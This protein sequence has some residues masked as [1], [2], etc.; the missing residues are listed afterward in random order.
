MNTWQDT[1]GG[2][3]NFGLLLDY[4]TASYIKEFGSKNNTAEVPVPRLVAVYYNEA[5][6]STIHD[7][8][9]AD[10]DASL[11][12]FT[13]TFDPDV[14]QMVSGY[15]VKSFL[16]FDLSSIPPNAAMATMRFIL[17]R[18]IEN[19]VVNNNLTEQMFVRVATS[20]YDVLPEYQI[21]STFAFNLFF[22]VVLTEISSNLL[23]ITPGDRGFSSQNF[24]Q[25]IINDDVPLGSFMVQY[26]NE[27]DGIS[28]Y[29]VRDSEYDEISRRP[30]IVVEY[31][32]VP[33]PR[34]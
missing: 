25:S 9:F 11:I 8:S 30:K 24:L 17:N 27:W 10:K 31:Y 6:D 18:D 1:T 33:N 32:N 7:T 12:D 5:L 2:G 16:K 14:L 3:N 29:A 34:L 20:D 4:N 13:G 19:S 28:V 22:N 21:D 15:S 23:D 26:R